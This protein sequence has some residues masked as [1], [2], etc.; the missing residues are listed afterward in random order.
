MKRKILLVLLGLGTIAGYASAFGSHSRHHRTHRAAFEEH[1]A[2]LCVR[3]A[4]RQS[5][6]AVREQRP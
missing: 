6:E 2:D 5:A 4:A 1:V 3:A